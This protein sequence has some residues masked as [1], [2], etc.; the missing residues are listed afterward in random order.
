M[1]KQSQ[2][3]NH[4]TTS[5]TH[6]GKETNV[7]ENSTSSPQQKNVFLCQSPEELRRKTTTREE[8]EKK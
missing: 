1:I 3:H 2:E 6:E 4:Y 7:Q 5:I 8:S